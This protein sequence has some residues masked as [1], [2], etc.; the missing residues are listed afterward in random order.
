MSLIPEF[1]L[2]LWNAWIFMVPFLLVALLS[3]LLMTKKD[4][5]GGAESSRLSKTTLL[6]CIVSKFI[7]F[8]AVIYSVFLPH[9]CMHWGRYG[10]TWVF[11]L[12]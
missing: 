4:A 12:L 6:F 5:P 1:E 7:I 10:S 2:S 3:I 11:Q 8:P 9:A